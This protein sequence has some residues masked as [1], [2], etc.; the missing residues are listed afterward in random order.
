[1]NTGIPKS[2]D[3]FE[4]LYDTGN[5]NKSLDSDHYRIKLF[6]QKRKY[7]NLIGWEHRFEQEKF[8]QQ[9]KRFMASGPGLA[10]NE[11]QVSLN[12]KL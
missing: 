11:L 3:T 4:C 1:M 9:R 8:A 10:G 12:K 2:E 5:K 7:S 6:S